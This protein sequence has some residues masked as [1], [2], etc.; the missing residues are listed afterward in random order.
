MGYVCG[1]VCGCVEWGLN[2]CGMCVGSGSVGFESVWDSNL[3]GV[4]VRVCVGWGLNLCGICV[5][6]ESVW[7]SRIPHGFESVLEVCEGGCGCV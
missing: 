3:C 5:G 6:S 7:D 2:L 4:C 1:C